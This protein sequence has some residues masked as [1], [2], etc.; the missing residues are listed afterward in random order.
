[1]IISIECNAHTHNEIIHWQ[2]TKKKNT[3]PLSIWQQSFF[4]FVFVMDSIYIRKKK[5][6]INEFFKKMKKIEE[7]RVWNTIIMM[8]MMV[9]QVDYKFWKSGKFILH[10]TF[11]LSFLVSSYKQTFLF[12][13][14]LL[15][16]SIKLAICLFVCSFVWFDSG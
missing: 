6:N 8:M 14:L 2:T 11:F 3:N 9:D 15:K 13:L 16:L 10:L 5:M 12:W 7:I 1:M 4:F